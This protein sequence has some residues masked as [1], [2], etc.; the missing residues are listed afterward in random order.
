M[1]IE[2]AATGIVRSGLLTGPLRFSPRSTINW[3]AAN[4][5]AFDSA[6]TEIDDSFP[7]SMLG[8]AGTQSSETAFEAS[9]TGLA[10][11]A[12]RVLMDVLAQVTAGVSA[13]QERLLAAQ[14]PTGHIAPASVRFLTRCAD[15]ATAQL[16][17]RRFAVL[18]L[19][20]LANVGALRK[21]LLGDQ[22]ALVEAALNAIDWWSIPDFEAELSI[23]AHGMGPRWLRD[24]AEDLLG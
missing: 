11:E 7:A 1:I 13:E 8:G 23:V 6:E 4:N 22:P 20:A 15:D 2:S 14:L 9:G 18:A 17:T 19:G 5:T 16:H 12:S 10:I 3:N 24:Y 21:A